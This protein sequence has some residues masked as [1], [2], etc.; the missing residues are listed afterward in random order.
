MDRTSTHRPSRRRAGLAALATG[1]AIGAA[2][3]LPA[4]AQARIV[5]GKSVA[6][7]KLGDSAARVKAVLGEPE[8]GSTVLNY[9]YIRSRGFGIY[10]IAGKAFEITVVRRP[11]ATG[12]GIGVGSTLAALRAA[13]PGAACT[14]SVLGPNAFDCSLRSRFA[15]RGTETQFKVRRG[16]VSTIA[17]RFA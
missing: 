6:G 9:R 16:K 8:R 7:V 11:Q 2:A 13:H 15:G 14:P 5:P 17:V 10:F 1:L 3:V 12:A 4:T